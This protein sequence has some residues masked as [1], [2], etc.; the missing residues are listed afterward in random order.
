MPG[1]TDDLRDDFFAHGREESLKRLDSSFLAYREQAGDAEVDLIDQRQV[2]P[3][4]RAKR[5]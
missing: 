2:A 4:K 5:V 3:A 1:N